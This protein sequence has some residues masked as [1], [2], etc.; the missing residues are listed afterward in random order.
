MLRKFTKQYRSTHAKATSEIR[1]GRKRSCWSWWIWPTNYRPGASGMSLT[2]ALSDGEA[3]V[4]MR[5]EYLRGCWIEMMTAVAE[6]LEAGVTPRKLCGIDAPRVPATCD[7][8]SRATGADDEQ[9]Q[10]LCARVATAMGGDPSKKRKAS[11]A[12]APSS[13]PK[14][15][16]ELESTA[17]APAALGPT[18]LRPAPAPLSRASSAGASAAAREDS[19]PSAATVTAS[20]PAAGVDHHPSAMRNRAPVSVAM[21]KLLPPE[22][23][24]RSLEV[25]SGTGAHLEMLAADFPKL[26]WRPSEYAVDKHVVRGFH[27][28]AE[29]P[30]R[31]REGVLTLD[32]LDSLLSKHEN[33]LPALE[34][35]VSQPF[36]SW[37]PELSVAAAAAAAAAEEGSG[38]G[39]GGDGGGGGGGPG[40]LALVYASNVL[41][42]APWTVAVGLF[43]GA[44]AAL[45]PGGSLMLHGPFK[46]SGKCA[47][48]ETELFVSTHAR[49]HARTHRVACPPARSSS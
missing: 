17:S 31:P 30:G 37:P 43:A 29:G 45:R 25:G 19:G 5:D 38:G 26:Q 24:G 34:L 46:T 14:A 41:H 12:K 47:N 1:G 48:P 3:A 20:A 49:T 42:I 27:E 23:A 11:G 28:D 32:A 39:D 2:Y 21:R 8:M 13:E 22:T 10:A 33:V 36:E 6:Q 44:G 35:D 7:L 40:S 15:P 9:V 16:S 4:F 18:P